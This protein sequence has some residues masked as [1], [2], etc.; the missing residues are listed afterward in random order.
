MVVKKVVVVVGCFAAS[1]AWFLLK[2]GQN[3]P[4]PPYGY[5]SVEYRGKIVVVRPP[6]NCQNNDNSDSGG[7]F[8]G[9]S[10]WYGH[11]RAC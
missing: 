1:T 9:G 6:S 3:I 7:N 10:H 8:F 2:F 4:G 11:A 5:G